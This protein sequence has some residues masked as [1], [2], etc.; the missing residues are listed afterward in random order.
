MTT[1]TISKTT[2]NRLAEIGRK[3]NTFDEI[4]TKIL[5]KLERKAQ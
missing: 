1:I 4:V 3:D 2:R 5:D